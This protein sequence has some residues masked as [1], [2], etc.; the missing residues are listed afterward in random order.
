MGSQGPRILEIDLSDRSVRAP[1]P[2]AARVRTSDDI[3]SVNVRSMGRTFAV[4]RQAPGLFEGTDR[5]PDIPFIFKGRS[6]SVD[7]V[8]TDANGR[9]VTQTVSVY[10]NR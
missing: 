2:I 3:V 10:L 9:S 8:A 7:F 4:A 1:G 5:L 6:Y